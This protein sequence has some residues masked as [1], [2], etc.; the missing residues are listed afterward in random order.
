MSITGHH[1]YSYTNM[2]KIQF[3]DIF[4]KKKGTKSFRGFR[5]IIE[6]REKNAYIQ[7]IHTIAK[8]T[9]NKGKTMI[10]ETIDNGWTAFIA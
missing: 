9:H 8:E 1:H 2:A 4:Q 6:R 5:I 3:I 7:Y 10:L